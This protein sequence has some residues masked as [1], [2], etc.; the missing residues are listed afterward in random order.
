MGF[1]RNSGFFTVKDKSGL[2]P[3][4]DDTQKLN[5]LASGVCG[6]GSFKFGIQ[7]GDDDLDLYGIIRLDAM[8]PALLRFPLLQRLC[9][10]GRSN[11]MES[12]VTPEAECAMPTIEE[13]ALRFEN[14]E[15]DNLGVAL[16]LDLKPLV[17]NYAA[18]GVDELDD[19]WTLFVCFAH[20]TPNGKGQ[21]STLLFKQH[22]LELLI[23]SED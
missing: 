7:P 20:P 2:F 1:I 12:V 14:A 4:I 11:F 3:L 17:Q 22:S 13:G 16:R 8:V 9:N 23:D 18:Q 10:V 21:C 15:S 19:E 6:V 5:L